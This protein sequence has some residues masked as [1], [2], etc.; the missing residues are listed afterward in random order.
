MRG[1]SV[2]DLHIARHGRIAPGM[3]G[4]FHATAGDR[5]YIREPLETEG[6]FL[7]RIRC[8]A[9]A[10]GFRIVQFGGAFEVGDDQ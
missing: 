6:D 2:V 3:A 7:A 5:H 9:R 1:A 10:D 8:Q 4:I